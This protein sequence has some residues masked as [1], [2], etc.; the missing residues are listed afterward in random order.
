MDT[1]QKMDL[2]LCR[3]ALDWYRDIENALQRGS[4]GYAKD[5]LKDLKSFLAGQTQHSAFRNASA[6]LPKSSTNPGDWKPGLTYSMDSIE[7]YLHKLEAELAG[8]AGS[9]EPSA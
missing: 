6:H 5:K 4:I 3:Q 8:E 9:P 1:N 7:R 2:M